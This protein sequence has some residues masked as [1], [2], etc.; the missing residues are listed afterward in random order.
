MAGTRIDQ[1]P[2]ITVDELEAGNATSFIPMADDDN[3][4]IKGKSLGLDVLK[5]WIGTGQ[6]GDPGQ[7][8]PT[9]PAGRGITTATISSGTLEFLY[10]DGTRDSVGN[11]VGPMGAPG[12]DGARGPA[13]PPGQDGEDFDPTANY[14]ISGNQTFTGGVDFSNATVVGLSGGGG[15][16]SF[17]I[18][19]DYSPSGNWSPTGTWNFSAATVTGLPT[20]GAAF[21]PSA[22][23]TIT[24][25]YT[26][27]STV[28]FS[29]A[30]VTGLTL[31]PGPAG[32]PGN[33]GADGA[34]GRGISSVTITNN[35]L[36]L[37]YTDGN[38]ANVGRVVGRDGSQGIPG[39]DGT[40]GQPGMPGQDGSDGVSITNATIT[41]GNLILS[42]SNGTTRNVGNVVGADGD[43]GAP[44]TPGLGI[45]NVT[46]TNGNLILSYSDG[47]NQNVGSVVGPSGP[48]GQPGNDG[49][50][51][52]E[53][54]NYTLTGSWNF[55][56]AT[57]T[58]IS[59][60][61]GGS[62]L[63]TADYSV[64][65]D[66]TFSGAVDFTNATVT[67][68]SS[69]G[70]TNPTP[71][72]LTAGTKRSIYSANSTSAF[73]GVMRTFT[74][75]AGRTL[76][77]YEFLD[78]K[79]NSG[80][81]TNTHISAREMITSQSVNNIIGGTGVSVP[82][83]ARGAGSIFLLVFD[84]DAALAGVVGTSNGVQI[85]NMVGNG[86]DAGDTTIN[87]ALVDL[88]TGGSSS[89]ITSTAD[90]ESVDGIFV[91][92]GAQGPRGLRGN[93]GND[94]AQGATG[95]QG[96]SVT[97]TQINSSG[98][99]ITTLSSG[100]NI[101]AGRA[102]GNTGATGSPGS[103]GQDGD[104]GVSV[105]NAT[106]NS[107]GNLI[108]TLSNGTS[109]NAGR[110][111]GNDGTDGTGGLVGSFAYNSPTINHLT[112]SAHNTSS[113]TSGHVESL[114]YSLRTSGWFYMTME[115]NGIE[116][117]IGIFNEGYIRSLGSISGTTFLFR[118]IRIQ[119]LNTQNLAGSQHSILEIGLLGTNNLAIS[120]SNVQSTW[121]AIRFRIWRLQK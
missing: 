112:T 36:I 9:G 106:I 45:T 108:L 51:F 28:D 76:N 7:R 79:I 2:R 32:T 91:S 48:P 119:A 50:D 96:V 80:A 56:G 10:S 75:P 54:G 3:G 69:S 84:G 26:F 1:K 27:Q 81:V 117:Y 64:S 66:W 82:L 35:N 14:T 89:D 58:G 111:R 113:G 77:D 94:G 5:T 83:E 98:N 86:C 71:E 103:P 73:R 6:D 72:G 100:Q 116:A 68:L 93:D 42:F 114:G 57:V 74:L 25:T 46:I 118:A 33:D 17:N 21:D 59:S 110:A 61:G 109:V 101:N 121:S 29:L 30:T 41:N 52:D 104:D 43:D 95:A 85:P 11:V 23:Q 87:V 49:A 22:N 47:S 90:V 120:F 65:G 12:Q 55:T 40:D 88:D 97:N 15:G 62:F 99:L 115:S 16:G 13:G 19:G 39:N 18:N 53:A 78:I 38:S 70:S 92:G 67:G 4:T 37:T 105:T 34:D 63:T 102:R 60:G 8:G 20:G 24:G 31:P 44:G 107:A